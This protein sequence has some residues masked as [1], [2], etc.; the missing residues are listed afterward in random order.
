[1]IF[2]DLIRET[3]IPLC[4][5]SQKILMVS[6]CVILLE[7]IIRIHHQLFTEFVERK[8]V[9]YIKRIFHHSNVIKVINFNNRIFIPHTRQP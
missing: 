1:M 7:N 8:D 4:H 5:K 3:I 2:S 6:C 9:K